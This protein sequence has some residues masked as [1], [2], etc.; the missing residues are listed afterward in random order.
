MQYVHYGIWPDVAGDQLRSSCGISISV[1][2]HLMHSSTTVTEQAEPSPTAPP[3][4]YL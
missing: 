4:K 3:C 2:Q 1:F